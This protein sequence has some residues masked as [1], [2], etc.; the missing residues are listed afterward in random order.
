MNSEKKSK[1]IL[2]LFMNFII[3]MAIIFT[4]FVIVFS[5]FSE[6]SIGLSNFGREIAIYSVAS[7]ITS[8][9]LIVIFTMKKISVPV[10]T[11]I[12]YSL[13]AIVFLTVGYLTYIFD[14]ASNARLFIATI[15]AFIIGGITITLVSY[16]RSNKNNNTLNNYLK[17]FKERGK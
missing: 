13:L 9:L 7:V 14:F 8:I 11:I 10:Q 4:L 15:V 3:I 5:S 17:R 16:I 6:Y 12:V 2:K 1:L